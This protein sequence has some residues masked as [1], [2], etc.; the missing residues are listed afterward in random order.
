M[1]SLG[2]KIKGAISIHFELET[3]SQ[4]LKRLLCDVTLAKTKNGNLSLLSDVCHTLN[5]K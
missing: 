4:G 1:V 5:R 3:Q 2:M